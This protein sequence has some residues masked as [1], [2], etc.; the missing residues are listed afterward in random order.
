[1]SHQRLELAAVVREHKKALLERWGYRVGAEQRQALRDIGACRTAALGGHLERCNSCAHRAIE[2]NSCRNRHCPKCQSAARDRWLG[3][4]AEELLPVAYCHVI[5]T[6]VGQLHPVALAN[7][8]VFY[9]LLF[10]AAAETLLEVATNPRLLGARIGVLALLHTWNQTLGYHPHIHCLV[11]A[12]GLSADGQHWIRCSKKF[13]LPVKVLRVKFRGK[14]LAFL[15]QAFE[16]GE[17]CFPGRL[18]ELADP[19]R[20]AAFLAPLRCIDWVLC[21]KEPLR[22]PEHVLKYLARYTYRSAISNGR[23]VSTENGRVQFRCRDSRQ[24]NRRKVVA[25]DA[26][27]FLR[28]FLLHLLPKGFIRIRYFGLLAH[29]NRS[30]ALTRCRRLLA[31]SSPPDPGLLSD[32]QQRAIERRC[33][34]CH[35]GL[36]RI[37]EWFSAAELLVRQPDLPAFAP[38]DSS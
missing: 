13:F 31:D 9:Q 15:Q 29:R 24:G 10:R 6:V 7:Q 26:V 35:S 27:E 36:L 16:R 3:A 4:R 5:F 20:F 28:R 19:A 37:V 23:L 32:E 38:F 34:R 30:A 11:P 2:F 18:A 17:L 8:R 14:L 21:V 33:P 12:G 22:R 1:V 25:L